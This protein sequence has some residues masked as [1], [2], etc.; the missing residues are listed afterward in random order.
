VFQKSLI[1]PGN[2]YMH[3]YNTPVGAPAPL[4]KKRLVYVFCICVKGHLKV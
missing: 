4:V 1:H 2:R 3:M